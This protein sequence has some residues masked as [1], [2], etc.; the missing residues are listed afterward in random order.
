EWLREGWNDEHGFLESVARST[1]RS[2]VLT[3]IQ[4]FG[5]LG[6]EWRYVRRLVLEKGDHVLKCRLVHDWQDSMRHE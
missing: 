5:V 3:Q 4:S 2:W 1:D 6:G